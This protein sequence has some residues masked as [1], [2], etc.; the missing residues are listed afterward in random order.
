MHVASFMLR[1]IGVAG[2]L[3]A[4]CVSGCGQPQSAP[5]SRPLNRPPAGRG[6]A[7]V[8]AVPV[9]FPPLVDGRLDEGIWQHS[10]GYDDFGVADAPRRPP[11]RR[12]E[13]RIAY[14]AANLYIALRGLTD[15]NLGPPKVRHWQRDDPGIVEDESCTVRLWPV[16]HPPGLYYEFTVNAR[17]VVLDA[18]RHW[19]HPVRSAVWDAPTQAAATIARGEWLA[20]LRIPFRR[21]GVP[22][23]PWWVDVVRH[24]ALSEEQSGL[25]CN[26]I[27]GMTK[28]TP[29]RALLRWPTPARPFQ[30]GPQPMRVLRLDDM[31]RA[32]KG[33][34]ASGAMI[35][36]SEQHVASGRRSMRI[37][38]GL[39]GGHVSLTPS[40]GSFSGFE[41]LRFD[42]F[43]GGDKPITM[44][45]R[46]R[47]VLAHTETG[48][49]RARPGANDVAL[50]LALLGAGLRL[51]SVKAV[52]LIGRGDASVWIDHLRLEQDTL[53]CHERPH[54]PPR[55]SRSTLTVSI[56]PGVLDA[57]PSP[58]AVAVDVTVPLY[59]T[60]K[61]RRLRRRPTMTAEHVVF[62][63]DEFA[64]HDARDPVR[65]TAFYHDGRQGRFAVREL[66]LAHPQE[67]V[68]LIEGDFPRFGRGSLPAVGPNP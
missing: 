40:Q 4:L 35:S 36:S 62:G 47:D 64:G 26:A 50:P 7:E 5:T 13:F 44:A 63:A 68:T 65:V 61:V 31:E 54:R 51:R 16:A 8:Q 48:W 29:P 46:L 23:E 10:P 2:L 33:W 56:D 27:D 57:L 28:S 45:V 14:D 32:P 53:S 34:R 19:G 25:A 60:R 1:S 49:F 18:R 15:T 11:Q 24:D 55:A 39:G 6:H 30:T 9:I 59:H 58:P 22:D 42:A 17:G 21:L 37:D 67:S 3:A 12:T 20:E 43:V 66:H 38:Y 52:E 41:T